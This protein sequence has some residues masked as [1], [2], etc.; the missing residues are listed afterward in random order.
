MNPC[1]SWSRAF[2][3]LNGHM[4]HPQLLSLQLILEVEVEAEAAKLCRAKM[5]KTGYLEQL[6]SFLLT[7]LSNDH[8]RSTPQCVVRWAPPA[9]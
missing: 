9:P 5:V 3:R 7:F 1:A 4:I 2:I 8:V 6:S